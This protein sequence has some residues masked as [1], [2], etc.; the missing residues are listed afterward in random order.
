MALATTPRSV[1]PDPD[2]AASGIRRERAGSTHLE[3]S[4][5]NGMEA[6]EY[7]IGPVAVSFA[8]VLAALIPALLRLAILPAVVL[9]ILFGVAIGPQSMGLVHHNEILDVLSELGLAILFLIA[10]LEVHP[11]Q[12]RGAPTRLALHG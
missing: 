1:I 4:G 11:S 12:V 10:G 7:A 6:A 5:R 2:K 9:E 3:L 8:I